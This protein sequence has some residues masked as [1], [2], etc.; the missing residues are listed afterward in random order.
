MIY[1]TYFAENFE[2]TETRIRQFMTLVNTGIRIIVYAFD[3]IDLPNATVIRWDIKDTQ[4]YKVNGHLDLPAIRNYEKDTRDFLILQN[5]KTELMADAISKFD[6][7]HYAWIDF[8]IVSLLKNPRSLQFLRE[9]QPIGKFLAMPG[10]TS[11]CAPDFNHIQWRFCGAFFVG[12]KESILEFHAKHTPMPQLT[13]EVNFWVFLEAEGWQPNWYCGNHDDSIFYLSADYYTTK[14]TTITRRYN[15][16]NIPGYIPSSA[17]HLF[18]NNQHILNTRYVNYWLQPDGSYIIPEGVIRNKNVASILDASLNPMTFKEMEEPELIDYLAVARYKSVG[19][20][21]IRL[22]EHNG[23]MRFIATSIN[24]SESGVNRMV[25][26]NYAFGNYSDCV[27]IESKRCEK[28]W[29]YIPTDLLRKWIR[30]D[31]E[32]FIYSWSPIT[33]IKI[34]GNKFEPVLKIEGGDHRVKGSTSFVKG[35][36]GYE[37]VVHFSEEHTPRHYYHMMVDENFKFSKPFYFEN[38]GIEFCIGFMITD[39]YYFWISQMDRDPLVAECSIMINS[40]SA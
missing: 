10:C 33:I 37:A 15:Y 32:H 9:L 2:N 25:I 38:L 18:Y 19:L 7:E 5:S 11:K 30:D 21:D 39:K 27:V 24:Y 36:R 3:D 35:P 20:E 1:V 14:L 40:V 17:S 28:N 13:W 4:C 22:Y 12:D 8:S 31:A 29:V 23:V 16:M 34:V 6:A 26:G